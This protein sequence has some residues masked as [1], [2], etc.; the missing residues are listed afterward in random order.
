MTQTTLFAFFF[1]V[2]LALAGAFAAGETRTT[3]FMAAGCALA[4]LML[5]SLV[6]MAGYRE[7]ERSRAAYRARYGE[8]PDA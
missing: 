6:E 7:R 5:S 8:D 2:L 1:T 3:L 4:A